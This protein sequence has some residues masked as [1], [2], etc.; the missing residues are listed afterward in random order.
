MQAH[1]ALL[2]GGAQLAQ[3][4]EAAHR[5]LVVIAIV[6]LERGAVSLRDV[7]C[8]VRETQELLRILRVI[9]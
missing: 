7:H 3:H 4:A 2:D 1:A 5:V 9:G 6:D 8:D